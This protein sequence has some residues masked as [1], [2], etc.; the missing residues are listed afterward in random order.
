MTVARWRG[1]GCAGALAWCWAVVRRVAVGELGLEG[2]P[3]GIKE[4]ITY[5]V[6]IC[7]IECAK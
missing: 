7:K 3:P 4:F 6:L 1:R 2:F 5:C